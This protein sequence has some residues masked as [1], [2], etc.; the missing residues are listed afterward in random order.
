MRY[1]VIHP[2]SHMTYPGDELDEFDKDVERHFLWVDTSLAAREEGVEH[3][4]ESQ[5]C[6]L[7]ALALYPN[8]VH[9]EDG[10]PV[11]R[12]FIGTTIYQTSR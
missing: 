2:P 3:G 8:H 10:T 4:S 11:T 6:C 1:H 7:V 12:K 9:P 5:H